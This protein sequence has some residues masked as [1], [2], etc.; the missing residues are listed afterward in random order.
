MIMQEKA[1]I[2]VVDDEPEMLGLLS[3]FLHETIGYTVFAA[4][5]AM[6]A[7]DLL[8]KEKI[9]LVLSD[10]NMPGMKGF[11]LL[12]EVRSK[13]PRIKRVLITAYNVEN[14]LEMAFK[15]D[16][17]NIFVKTTPFNFQELSTMLDSLLSN[18]IFGLD[19]HFDPGVDQSTFLVRRSDRLDEDAMKIVSKVDTTERA[20][21]LELVLVELLT[22]A[23]FYGIRKESPDKKETWNHNFE[24]PPEKAIQIKV[25]SD[26]EK[27]GISVLDRGGRLK[28]SDVLF[29]L[30]RQAMRDDKGLPIGLYDSHGRGFFIV[31]RYIDRLIINIDSEKQTEVIILNY[32]SDTYQGFKPLHINEL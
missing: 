2:L 31:R 12:N 32:Y 28:K 9:D 8:A 27:Y 7:L 18:D 6:E 29:W 24:L 21:Q 3:D 25:V 1:R 30:H 13:Y 26:K 23:I 11:E 20:K 4:P 16:I 22:N 14:Y 10:I 19:R 15:Y 5:N 17:G